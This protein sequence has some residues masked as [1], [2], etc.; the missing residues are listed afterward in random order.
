[1]GKMPVAMAAKAKMS[2]TARSLGNPQGE[3]AALDRI[4]KQ[5]YTYVPILF[6]FG[7]L[8]WWA[9]SLLAPSFFFFW[10]GDTIM[11][12]YQQ[13]AGRRLDWHGHHV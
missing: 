10:G 4:V 5:N 3:S 12:S 9:C 13:G 2:R 1:M 6:F 8:V 7:L 11:I